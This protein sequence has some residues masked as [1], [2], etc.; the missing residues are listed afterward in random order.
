MQIMKTNISKSR[1]ISIFF[2]GSFIRADVMQSG[3]LVP[4]SIEVAR[5]NGF[6]ISINPHACIFRS[7][8][9]CIYGILVKATH[10]QLDSKRP[11][12]PS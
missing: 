12:N 4:E 6:D 3:G 10:A 11:A 7:V 1:Q 8:Q 2:Y 9:C 5:L